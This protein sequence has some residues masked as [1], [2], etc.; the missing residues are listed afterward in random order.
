MQNNE[1]LLHSLKQLWDI[2]SPTRDADALHIINQHLD[3]EREAFEEQLAIQDKVLAKT[4]QKTES[5][6]EQLKSLEAK[7]K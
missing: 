3:Q 2:R 4:R 1:D 7:T 5:L 6:L